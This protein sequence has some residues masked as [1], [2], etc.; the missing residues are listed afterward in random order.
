[1]QWQ[2]GVDWTPGLTQ[3]GTVNNPG[4]AA[5]GSFVWKYESVTG[6]GTLSSLDPWYRHER[7]LL[8]WDEQWWNTGAGAWSAGDNFSPPV[9]QDRIIHNL[10][11]TTFQHTPVV[12]WVNPLGDGAEIEV[13]GSLTLRWTGSGGLGFPVDVDVIIAFDDA[14]SG[15]ITPLFAGTYSKPNAGPSINDQ[16][17]IPIV[18]SGPVTFDDGDALLVSHRGHSAFGP[19]GMWVTVFDDVNLT[20]VPS[21]GSLVL[22]AAAG[23]VIGFRRRR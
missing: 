21:P 12:S 8:K 13:T 19:V 16:V 11:T 23:L 6:G 5:G 7:T 15:Q 10:H 20:M 14:S 22:L 2:R 1:M 3:G 4:P 17:V 9:M 18:L